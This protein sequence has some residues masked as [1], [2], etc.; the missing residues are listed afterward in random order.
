[1]ESC[2]LYKV[3]C[4]LSELFYFRVSL[5]WWCW[6]AV[7]QPQQYHSSSINMGS[8]FLFLQTRQP[9]E[10]AG[11]L[12]ASML[13]VFQTSPL[14]QSCLWQHNKNVREGF[15]AGT[16][17]QVSTYDRQ[18]FKIKNIQYFQML[19]AIKDYPHMTTPAKQRTYPRI[20]SL[21][22]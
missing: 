18:H 11:S 5:L 6:P 20:L 9:G 12:L 22:F 10:P 13:T 16:I 17:L 2:K 19:H 21:G 14:L 3:I 4:I 1:M 15:V 7:L 8:I